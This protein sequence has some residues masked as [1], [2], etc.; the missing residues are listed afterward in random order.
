VRYEP[1][2]DIYEIRGNL[3]RVALGGK[4]GPARRYLQE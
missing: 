3:E 2:G 1:P 4:G